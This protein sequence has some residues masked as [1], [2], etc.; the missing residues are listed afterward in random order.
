M[1]LNTCAPLPIG[2]A[3][4]VLIPLTAVEATDLGDLLMD[5]EN[6]ELALRFL[7]LAHK[8]QPHDTR[9]LSSLA[10]CHEELGQSGEAIRFLQ[11][12]ADIDPTGSADLEPGWA[13]VHLHDHDLAR[14]ALVR[15]L[16]RDPAHLLEIYYDGPVWAPI[17]YDLEVMRAIERA[18]GLLA[19]A[20]PALK[21]DI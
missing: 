11:Q 3:Q 16:Q 14:T 1:T 12:A 19:Q 15:A 6:F 9:I 13:A 2:H 17:R 5:A 18:A 4:P 20:K 10:M 21:T 7:E 8:S